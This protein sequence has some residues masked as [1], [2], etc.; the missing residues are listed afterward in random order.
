MIGKYLSGYLDKN[1]KPKYYFKKGVENTFPIMGFK[2]EDFFINTLYKSVRCGLY[3]TGITQVNVILT[4]DTSGTIGYQPEKKLIKIC[5]GR[6]VEDIE[7]K[8]NEYIGKIRNPKNNK[9][10]N[11]FET[12]FDYENTSAS[13]K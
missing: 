11:N 5:P 13:L 9:M 2:E 3:H 7:A 12:R 4:C 1:K 6:L 10:R 8:F